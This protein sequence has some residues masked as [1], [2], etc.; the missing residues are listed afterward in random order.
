MKEEKTNESQAEST[1]TKE[2]RKPQKQ[3]FRNTLLEPG[4]NA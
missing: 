2:E 4:E 1:T 3:R